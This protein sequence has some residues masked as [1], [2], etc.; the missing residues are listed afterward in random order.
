MLDRLGAEPEQLQLFGAVVPDEQTAQKDVYDCP[1][2]YM[3]GPA[4]TFFSAACGHMVC[5]SDWLI[6]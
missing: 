3:D 1:I 5:S 2:C 4:D 6:T